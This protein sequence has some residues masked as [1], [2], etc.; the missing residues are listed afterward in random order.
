[1]TEVTVR[2]KS[3]NETIRISKV[4]EPKQV[5]LRLGEPGR[6]PTSIRAWL[7]PLQA[8]QI[9]YRILEA[10]AV[11]EAGS[12]TASKIST[13]SRA[14]TIKT[15]DQAYLIYIEIRGIGAKRAKKAEFLPRQAKQLAYRL[16]ETTALLEG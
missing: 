3:P 5:A 6:W 12:S 4:L 13:S 2:T 8:E 16:L 11:A 7:S 9:A 15:Q 1:M 10:I 14:I